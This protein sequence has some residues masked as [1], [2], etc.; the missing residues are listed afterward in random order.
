MNFIWCYAPLILEIQMED[1]KEQR[2][3]DGDIIDVHQ[4]VNGQRYFVV[5][6]KRPL[7]IRYGYDLTRKYE[8]DQKD[9]LAPS[10]ITYEV[11]WEIIGSIYDNIPNCG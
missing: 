9:L 7:D 10:K 4:T 8:Y 6:Q 5:L 11:D 2:L 3:K 1:I